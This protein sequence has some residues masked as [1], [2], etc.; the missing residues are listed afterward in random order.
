MTDFI[1]PINTKDPRI[2]NITDK[3]NF[4]VY[5]GASLNSYYQFGSISAN[6][7]QIIFNCAIPSEN[8]IIDRNILIN[9]TYKIKLNITGVAVGATAFNYGLG[10]CFQAFPIHSS[11]KNMT[12]SLNNTS[13]SI[14]TQDV[15]QPLLKMIEPRELQRYN[16]MSPTMPDLYFNKYI[17][18]VGSKADPTAD[19]KESGYDNQLIPRGAHPLKS[20]T[21]LHTKTAGG[22][23]ASLVSTN[24][25][26]TWVITL[27]SEFTEPLL[28]SP[29]LFHS[30]HNYNN[31]GIYGI[32]TFNLSINIDTSL[33]RFFTTNTTNINNISISFDTDNP[34]TN[35]NLLFNF[36]NIQETDDDLPTKNIVPYIDYPVYISADSDVINAGQTKTLFSQ[37]FQLNQVPDLLI[38]CVRRPMATMNIGNTNSFLPIRNI[39]INFNNKSGI[40]SSA[41]TQDLY[42]L[43]KVNGSVQSWYEFW[44]YAG[45]QNTNPAITTIGQYLYT[46]SGSLVIIN[47]TKD[48]GLPYY[49]S[50]GSIGN[51]NIQFKISVI[52]NTPDNFVPEIVIITANSG[53]LINNSGETEIYTGILSKEI[54]VE[55]LFNKNKIP[56]NSNPLIGSGLDK[57]NDDSEDK[58]KK[59]LSLLDE[60]LS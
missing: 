12:C 19:Y 41:T 8:T 17:D 47:P 31:Q 56:I 18:A 38:L 5:S 49:L 7:N 22:T 51:Y 45:K 3:L 39:S 53:F 57:D 36:L 24:V 59:K 60:L 32:S 44:G 16:G 54:V 23:D 37:N 14:N 20:I 43:S 9:A 33:K 58:P 11:I 48:L 55:T 25:N 52:N 50:N 2:E 15:L 1:N 30:K 28:I 42:R 29:F 26:D 35:A 4:P 46:T 10:E 6:N 21:V 34:I 40:L 13:F 27:E